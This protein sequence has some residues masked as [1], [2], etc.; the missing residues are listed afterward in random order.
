MTSISESPVRNLFA[1]NFSTV[2]AVIVCGTEVSLR[3]PAAVAQ[4]FSRAQIS[5]YLARG[6][7]QGF[8][9]A[10][11]APNTSGFSRWENAIKLVVLCASVSPW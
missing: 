10:K 2:A 4:P 5:I 6:V 11:T 7:E 3:Y 8:S 1:L 9:P